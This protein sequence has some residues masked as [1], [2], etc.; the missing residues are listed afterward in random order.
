MWS[1]T[2]WKETS[3]KVFSFERHEEIHPNE[4]RK[5]QSKIFTTK[6]IN[7]EKPIDNLTVLTV[8]TVSINSWL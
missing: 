5:T 2:G 4:K 6:D 7:L 1:F 8:G 3:E